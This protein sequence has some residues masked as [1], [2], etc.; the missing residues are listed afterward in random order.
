MRIINKQRKV[1]GVKQAKHLV[2]TSSTHRND[3][4][5]ADHLRASVS[6]E[7]PVVYRAPIKDAGSI[8]CQVL[9]FSR[10]GKNKAK[11]ANETEYV[12]EVSKEARKRSWYMSSGRKRKTKGII[13]TYVSLPPWWTKVLNEE[14]KSGRMTAEQVK[15]II[16]KLAGKAMDVLRSR[17][18][19]EPLYFAVHPESLNNMHVH[20]GVCNISGT[21]ELLGRSAGGSKGK[22]GLRHAGDC[23]LALMRM[24]QVIPHPWMR[25]G[26]FKALTKDCDDVAMA[27]AIDSTLAVLLPDRVERAKVLGVAHVKEWLKRADEKTTSDVEVLRKENG[28][29]RVE[30]E[31]LKGENEI[32]RGE[33]KVLTTE[34]AAVTGQV[35]LSI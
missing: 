12:K 17:T 11:Y 6:V 3:Q 28:E 19:Y 31:K 5:A 18:G 30:N 20:F 26:A 7:T 10:D 25:K 32:L 14:M 24:N 35:D 1:S 8:A 16:V 2:W 23:N 13:D 15:G 21:N 4:K 34:L 22:R 33:I 9:Y 29:L 27:Q